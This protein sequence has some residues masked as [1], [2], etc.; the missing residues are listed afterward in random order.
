MERLSHYQIVEK[1]G[2]GGMGVVYKARDTRLDRFVAIKVISSDLKTDPD[3]RHRFV[4]EAKAASALNHPGIITVHEIASEGDV[5]FI[6]MELVPGRTLDAVIPRK[7]M[8]VR[9]ALSVAVEIADALAAAHAAGIVHRDLKPANLMVSESGRAKVLDFGLAKLRAHDG[10]AREDEPTE[11]VKTREGTILGTCAYMSPEQAEGRSLDFRTDIFSF[12]L[13]LYEMLTGQSAFRR[14]SKVATLAAILREEP[15][16]PRELTDEVPPELERV[17]LRCLRK[18][19][20]RRFQTMA[21]LKVALAELKEESDSGKLSGALRPAE[22]TQPRRRFRLAVAA[23][24]SAVVA[25]GA[26]AVLLRLVPRA[27]GRGPEVTPPVPL[28]SFTG[29]VA[30]PALSPD[31]DQVAFVWNGERQESFDLYLK[32]VGPGAPIRLTSDPRPESSPAWSPD[33]RQIAFLRSGPAR[34]EVVVIPALGGPERTVAEAA[35]LNLGLAWSPD[36]RSLLVARAEAQGTPAGIFAVSV[37]AGTM[38]RLTRPPAGA[39]AGDISPALSPDGRTLAF[40]RSLTRSNSEIY[41]VPLSESL[42]VEGEPRRLTFETKSSGEPVFTPDGQRI[43]FSSV[44]RWPRIGLRRQPDGDPGLGLRREGRM[45]ARH[46]GGRVGH[47]LPAGEARL[48]A[49]APGREH[50]AAAHGERQGRR[51]GALHRL[52]A[53]GHR[54]AVLR[55]READ[56]L[57]LGP[58]RP[59]RGVDLRGGRL[60]TRPADVAAR[61]HDLRGP[62][63][64]GR[65]AGRVPLERGRP[66]G[67]LPHDAERN[68]PSA[69]DE[70][71]GPR[72]R[73]ALL[74]RREVDLLRLESR[75]RVPGLEDAG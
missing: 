45:G 41:V 4:Q 27:G 15:K 74:A 47:L 32:L 13:V 57:R 36:G 5:D 46:R 70:R 42:D 68:H 19:P 10:P 6:V 38:K 58:V 48:P 20:A 51:P 23:A 1:L 54:P 52:H 49:L 40:A 3:R 59:A 26:G 12:G 64:P 30:S 9:D 55:R 43:V 37:G 73:A 66:D 14:D 44:V 62:L 28:T 50:L 60:R 39:W 33:G 29:R 22:R 24:A 25:V 69:A 61:D 2:E 7:G 65:P 67:A 63:V 35:V 56:H 21:D 53:A 31:G 75:G 34:S 71:P 17:V 16:P 72:Q 8:R 18:D 11:R